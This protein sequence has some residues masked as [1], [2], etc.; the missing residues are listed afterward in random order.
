[1]SSSVRMCA[2]C[3]KRIRSHHPHIGLIELES[4]RELSSYHARCQHR[5]A[6]DFAAMVERGRAYVVRHFHSSACPDAAPGWGC[7]GGCFDEPVAVA[8]VWREL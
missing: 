1:M 2:A 7:S 3:T 8:N 5:V 4:G 6:A